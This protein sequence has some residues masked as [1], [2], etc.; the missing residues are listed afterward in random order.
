MVPSEYACICGLSLGR[1]LALGTFPP[2]QQ[3]FV[4]CQPNIPLAKKWSYCFQKHHSGPFLFAIFLL[5]SGKSELRW[6]Y[7]GGFPCHINLLS[8]ICGRHEIILWPPWQGQVWSRVPCMLFPWISGKSTTSRASEYGWLVQ[9]RCSK[10]CIF[11]E[12][13]NSVISSLPVC[14]MSWNQSGGEKLKRLSKAYQIFLSFPPL[15]C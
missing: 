10:F 1:L 2:F 11:E 14:T 13:D 9:Y 15:F 5:N 4:L 3:H 6:A 8:K 12:G 7:F